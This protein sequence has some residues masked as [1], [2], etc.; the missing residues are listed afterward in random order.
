[1]VIGPNSEQQIKKLQVFGRTRDSKLQVQTGKSDFLGKEVESLRNIIS[2]DAT[3][4]N[5]KKVEAIKNQKKIEK[6]RK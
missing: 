5:S 6:S 1:M 4:T 2:L 3:K